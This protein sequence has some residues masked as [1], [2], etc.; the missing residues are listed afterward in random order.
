MKLNLGCGPDIREGW[1]NVDKYY[2]HPDVQQ[3][4]FTKLPWDFKNET[5]ETIYA[6]HVLE[7]I[8]VQHL[9][10]GRDIF[11]HIM[12]EIHRV[13]TPGGIL[14]LRV[15]Y[16]KDIDGAWGNPTHYRAITP[17]W[18]HFFNDRAR[19]NYY[20]TARFETADWRF[21]KVGPKYGDRIPIHSLALNSH[22]WV[23]L[24]WLRWAL[25]GVREIE[26]WMVKKTWI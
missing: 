3:M 11:W 24:P 21:R 22:L 19:E 5:F 15:P 16:A 1:L 2:Q 9:P 14:H 7:H 17:A 18:F 26:A 8:P 10:D 20:T 4:D 13:L 23:R 6:S 25:P 12:E